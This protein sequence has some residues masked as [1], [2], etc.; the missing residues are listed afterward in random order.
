[1]CQV[2]CR[3]E[4]RCGEHVGECSLGRGEAI[5]DDAMCAI[6]ELMEEAFEFQVENVKLR[7]YIR[8]LEGSVANGMVSDDDLERMFRTRHKEFG[9]EVG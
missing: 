4:L 2:G 9:I 1:M 5:P 7:K 8:W 3:Y 6:D